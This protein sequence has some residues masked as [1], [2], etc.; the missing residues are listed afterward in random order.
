MMDH[1]YP[2]TRTTA[3]IYPARRARSAPAGAT[4]RWPSDDDADDA[5][6]G[7]TLAAIARYYLNVEPEPPALAA[8]RGLAVVAR[9]EPGHVRDTYLTPWSAGDVKHKLMSASV[10]SAMAEDRLLAAAALDI[11]ARWARSGGRE[12]AMTAAIAFGGAL[13]QR[14][15]AEAMRWLWAMRMRDEHVSRVA[16]LAF[17]RLFVVET[18]TSSRD[19]NVA[20]F[21]VH[22]VR[23]LRKTEAGAHEH[24]SALDV[25]SAVLGAA[26]ADSPTPAVAHLLRA[27]HADLRPVAEVWAAALNSVPHRRTAVIALHLTLASLADDADSA[28]LAAALGS[29]ILPS[30]TTRTREVLKLTL[31][32][33]QRTEAIS[34][35][36]VTAFLGAQREMVS[37]DR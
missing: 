15:L 9:S 18:E 2:R 37:T 27:G 20:A 34:A 8:A 23:L 30:L 11:A 28:G 1:G 24:R 29:A 10:L 17:G 14:H 16:S 5:D 12:R 35:R 25:V 13:G 4:G 36:L 22:K 7:K 21:L 19:S 32:D 26:G 33:P 6:I 31:P 3:V